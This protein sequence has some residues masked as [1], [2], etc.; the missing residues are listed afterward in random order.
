MKKIIFFARFA[1]VLLFCLLAAGCA[2][3]ISR[4]PSSFL[5]ATGAAPRVIVLASDM[6]V[7]PSSGYQKT[8]KVDSKWKFVGR[9][10][11]GSVFEIQDDVFMLEGKHMHE[12][13]LVISSA[14][15]LVGFFLP[16]EEAFVPLSPSVQLSLKN[17]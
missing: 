2:A 11:Q 5:P 15:H 1:G 10:P 3:E 16:V 13:Q 17:K 14:D 4:T 8:L 12:A 9:I 7:T 6:E